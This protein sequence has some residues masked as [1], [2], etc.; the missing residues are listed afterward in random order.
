MNEPDIQLYVTLSDPALD[1]EQLDRMTS[2]VLNDLRELG[3]SSAGRAPGGNAPAG[4]KSVDPSTLGALLLVA[5]P[6]VLPKLIDFFQALVLPGENRK[7]RVKT[8]AGVEIEF[9]P[10][11]R[12]SEDEV[13]ALAKK[14]ARIR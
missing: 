11:R 10:Q 4:A 5:V 3:V 13:L 7:V 6:A 9:T 12:L 2:R 1:A 14:M 8:A